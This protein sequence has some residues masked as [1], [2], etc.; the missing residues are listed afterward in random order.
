[1]IEN[2]AVRLWQ[3]NTNVNILRIWDI[4]DDKGIPP[5]TRIY[6]IKT[7]IEFERKK[8]NIF[9]DQ[10]YNLNTFNQKKKKANKKSSSIDQQIAHIHTHKK[11][12]RKPGKQ[13]KQ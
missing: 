6:N 13:V 4:N 9:I 2:R 3:T 7:N 1:M 5:R 8:L 10:P 11:I 12:K